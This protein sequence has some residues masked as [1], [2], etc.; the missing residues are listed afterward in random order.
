MELII[1]TGLAVILSVLSPLLVQ[2]LTKASWSPV[3]KTWVAA[4]IA[5]V[6]AALYIGLTGGF[7]L[8]DFSLGIEAVLAAAGTALLSVYG[9]QQ[10]IFN[11]V[12]K[13]SGL[14]NALANHGVTDGESDDTGSGF[15]AED[16]P[17]ELEALQVDYVDEDDESPVSSDYEPK[18]LAG[19]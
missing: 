14:Q 1:P 3:A 17:E 19:E 2:Y 8:I 11:L 5:L 4:G 16:D 15:E 13:G 7:G 9:L 10:A 6:I 18:H 12:F